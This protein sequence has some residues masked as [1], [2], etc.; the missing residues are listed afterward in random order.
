[1]AWSWG[2]SGTTQDWD[3]VGAGIE[4]GVWGGVC[5][6]VCGG[7]GLGVVVASSAR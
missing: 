5:G 7:V 1:V 3:G 2:W 6:G 4:F